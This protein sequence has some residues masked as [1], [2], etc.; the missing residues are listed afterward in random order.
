MKLK[1][2]LL[3]LPLIVTSCGYKKPSLRTHSVL[4][5]NQSEL[6]E[7]QYVEKYSM[8]EITYDDTKR[9]G[10]DHNKRATSAANIMVLYNN[11]KCPKAS[12]K[13]AKKQGA[14][15]RDQ[16]IEN[17]AGEVIVNATPLDDNKGNRAI[18][19]YTVLNVLPPSGCYERMDGIVDRQ[20]SMSDDYLLGCENE[21]LIGQ[22][23][24]RPS[25]LKGRDTSSDDTSQRQSVSGERYR[26]G[27][28]LFSGDRT[29][30]TISTGAVDN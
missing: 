18:I 25:D 19:S 22:M 9:L 8:S 23:V 1:I 30:E 12:L 26:S 11:G 10:E 14:M 3:I 24:A 20:F 13:L 28:N 4:N 27:E 15:I 2:A 16:M 17:G 5:P 29:G 21:R 7:S 6:A